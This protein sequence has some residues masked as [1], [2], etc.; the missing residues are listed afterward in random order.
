[1]GVEERFV[2]Q[3]IDHAERD[4]Q[5]NVHT[6]GMEIFWL[7]LKRGLSGPTSASSHSTVANQVTQITYRNAMVECRT[8]HSLQQLIGIQMPGMNM[9]Y[10]Y[11]A[12]NNN[13]QITQAI[14]SVSGEQITYQ[15]DALK[16]LISAA[17]STTGSNPA[18]IW[19]QTFNYAGFGNL[20]D[21]NPTAGSAPPLHQVVDPHSNQISPGTYDLNGNPTSSGYL[22]DVENLF[23][24]NSGF[25]AT[26]GPDNKRL[27]GTLYG[28]QWQLSVYGID[29]RLI[30]RYLQNA[31]G[32]FTLSNQYR[33]FAGKLVAQGSPTNYA[34]ATDRLGSVRYTGGAA[35]RFLSL[36][37]GFLDERGERSNRDLG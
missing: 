19:G 15:Y 1:M 8:Y 34:V 16:R 12:T 17:S 18:P 33:Y 25:G 2:H 36:R 30:A 35:M 21:M 6:N 23:I 3:V 5:G 9:Q 13:G 14:D 32:S 37:P 26:Y 24:S 11:S 28:G 7:L 31:N 10:V 29:G 20:T 27:F 22:Y 4:V